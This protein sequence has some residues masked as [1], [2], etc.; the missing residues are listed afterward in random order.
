MSKIKCISSQHATSAPLL[1]HAQMHHLIKS[2][3][4]LNNFFRIRSSFILFSCFS[5]RDHLFPFPRSYLPSC[6]SFSRPLSPRFPPLSLL[7][8]RCERRP[9]PSVPSAPPSPAALP[10]GTCVR[11]PPS[12]CN[13]RTE[14]SIL[15]RRHHFTPYP[16]ASSWRVRSPAVSSCNASIDSG[17]GP[18]WVTTKPTCILFQ[19]SWKF[20]F[21]STY[22]HDILLC[23]FTTMTRQ[24]RLLWLWWQLWQSHLKYNYDGIFE[25]TSSLPHALEEKLF[26]RIKTFTVSQ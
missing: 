4:K 11:L 17:R 8:S 9:R 19:K 26:F 20:I 23:R 5:R 18:G 24:A 22:L 10:S 2:Y 1:P 7:H 13:G 15:P 21:M 3:I 16:P 12:P 25:V 14:G 6:S